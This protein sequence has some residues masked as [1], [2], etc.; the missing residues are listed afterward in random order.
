MA[1]QH[2]LD[3]GELVKVEGLLFIFIFTF[4][5]ES[6]P[7]YDFVKGLVYLLSRAAFFLNR[8]PSGFIRGTL[9]KCLKIVHNPGDGSALGSLWF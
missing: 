1:A 2:K 7:R 8:V 3:N 9:V 5:G 4:L 6:E